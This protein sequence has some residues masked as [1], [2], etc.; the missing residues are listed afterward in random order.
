MT[1]P[2]TQPTE[3][4]TDKNAGFAERAKKVFV[5]NYKPAP[6][7]LDR[8]MGCYVWDVEGKRYLDMVAGIAV[9]ALGHGHPKL[10][11]AIRDQAGKIIH[12]SNL[13][14]NQPS[15]ELAERLVASSFADA[16][17]FSNSGA[18]A[19]EAAIKLARRVAYDRGENERK[20]IVCFEHSFHGRT[21]GSLAATGQPKYHEGFGPLPG[22]FRHIP[23]GDEGAVAAAVGPATAALML[24]PIQ[25]ES[26]VRVPPSGF[27]RACREACDRAGALLIYD[28]V[29]VGLG[30]TG[31]L[32]CHEHEGVPPDILTL[33]KGIGG[34]LPLGA[35]LTT[36]KWAHALGYGTHATT[37]G[38]NP[39][40]TA[41]GRVVLD[42]LGEDGF[43]DHVTQMGLRLSAGLR[44]VGEGLFSEVR[45]KGL[46]IGAELAPGT[47]F[48]A[49][50]VVTACRARSLLVH[51]AGPRVVRLAPPLIIEAPQVDEA[52]ES[53]S[54]ALSG[55]RT[56]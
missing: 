40:A 19:N 39:V 33:A 25:G 6:L 28:E 11:E 41:A 22:G 3:P 55:L 2:M 27:L 46:L 38:G 13:Y 10:V 50:E 31:K 53:L 49:M 20:E 48:D 12:T 8:G 15:I 24:E 4:T 47:K 21:M 44:R 34:G 18:E 54:A 37:F 51:V 14:L 36:T 52:L 42:A 7:V 17:F 5:P 16:V 45:G 32:F 1:Q 9:S 30:R 56:S 29:Q 43:L 35:M 23:Y 26:G